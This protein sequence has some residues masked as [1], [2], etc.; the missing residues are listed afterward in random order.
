MQM[1]VNFVRRVYRGGGAWR[2]RQSG[3]YRGGGQLG[4]ETHQPVSQV[5][6]GGASPDGHHSQV[7]PKQSPFSG[8]AQTVTILR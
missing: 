3:R 2:R 6:P 4:A 8:E 5:P 1:L 7:R